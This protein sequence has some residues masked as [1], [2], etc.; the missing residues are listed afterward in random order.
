MSHVRDAAREHFFP[1]QLGVAVPGG[2]EVAI[3]TVRAWIDRHSGSR[4]VLIKLDFANAFNSVRRQDVV[5]ATRV[6]F[7][8]LARFVAWAYGRPTNL[9]FGETVI[10]SASGV[11]QGDPLGPLLFAAAIQPLTVELRGGL[12]LGLFFLDDGVLAGDI[13]AVGA[14][15]AH[16]QR[17]AAELGLQLNL[18]KC[19][20]VAVGNVSAADVVGHLP[21]ALLRTPDG[22]SKVLQHFE[23][24]LGAPIGD[25]ASS[26]VHSK[27]RV[28]QT[29]AL[30]DAIGELEA[31]L[32]RGALS[33][34]AQY[35]ECT[36]RASVASIPG[37]RSA[38]SRLL[39][40]PDWVALDRWPVDAGQPWVCAGRA[41]AEGSRG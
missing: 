31:A 34:C 26:Q 4:K 40:Q 5:N 39:Q 38:S 27:A 9:R 1:T 22:S 21:D 29:K 2:V 13:P 32:L 8:G 6:H 30:L 17:R 24:L 12:D 23:E 36:A 18:R 37:V 41:W 16:T 14:A 11:Q 33:H 3:H 20:A 19:E 28:D 25:S 35:A 10:P 15:L 7:P